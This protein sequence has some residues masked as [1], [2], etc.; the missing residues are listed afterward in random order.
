MTQLTGSLLIGVRSMPTTRRVVMGWMP[1]RRFGMAWK[2][3]LLTMLNR[4]ETTRGFSARWQREGGSLF[5]NSSRR[6]MGT[7]L[8]VYGHSMGGKLTVATTGT[9]KRVKA[10]AP[11]C[12]GISDRYNANPLY[13]ATVGDAPGFGADR[14]S[15]HFSKT[16]QRLSWA[17][18]Q[19]GRRG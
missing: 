4:R 11:S 7:R 9:D 8:G 10:A 1:S 15:D 3:G 2:T 12:G 14:V 17:N 19:H 18:F 13:N 16:S 5:S 6:W